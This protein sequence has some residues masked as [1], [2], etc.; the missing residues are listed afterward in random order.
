VFDLL[1]LHGADI[2]SQP[3][4]ERKRELQRLLS[5]AAA[6]SALRYSDHHSGKG[7]A[8]FAEA[9]KQRL[10]G[11]ISKQTNV[12]YEARPQDSWLN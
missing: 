4:I 11:I 1:Y 9:C 3:L 5:S 7:E 12:P 10:K 6:E 2:S 8:M